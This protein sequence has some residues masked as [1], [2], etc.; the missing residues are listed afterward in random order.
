MRID[1]YIRT[2]HRPRLAPMRGER[3]KWEKQIKTSAP[4][5]FRR[6]ETK[7]NDIISCRTDRSLPWKRN[8]VK[9]SIT[10]QLISRRRSVTLGDNEIGPHPHHR[11]AEQL[12]P[13]ETAHNDITFMHVHSRMNEKRRSG[14]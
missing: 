12:A 5:D 4:T 9:K 14:E 2:N 10:R 13:L 1:G 6:Q 11:D 7:I 3:L 8:Q